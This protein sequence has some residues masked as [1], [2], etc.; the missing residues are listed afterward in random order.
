M[1]IKYIDIKELKPW[2]R[3]PRK[4]DIESLKK[5]I[6]AFG[7]RSPLVVNQNATGYTVEAGHGRL[8]AA[9]ELGYT[10]LP[11]CIVTD[12]E[13]TAMAY[14][15][16]DNRQ[17]ELSEWLNDGLKDILQ[18]LDDGSIDMSALGFSDEYLEELMTQTHQGGNTDDDAVPDEAPPVCKLGEIWQLGEHRLLC[19]DST[20]AEDVALLMDGQKADMVFTDPP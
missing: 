14:A 19:G 13:K 4:H 10:E 9:L 18:E 5:S 12:D 2:P 7:F 15:L 3:N 20:K 8:E 1:E 6:V 16:A 11:C 17:Q